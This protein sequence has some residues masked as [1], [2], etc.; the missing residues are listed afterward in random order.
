MSLVSPALACRF[1]PTSVTY[2]DPIETQVQ[3][4]LGTQKSILERRGWW[5]EKSALF[6]RRATWG[7]GRLMPYFLL[8]TDNQGTQ[9]FKGHFKD[10]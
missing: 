8:P 10:V 1:F 3:L 9:A 6:Q 4:Q 5:K 7:E 2:V